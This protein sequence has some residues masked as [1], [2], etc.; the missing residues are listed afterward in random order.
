VL[1][2]LR[3]DLQAV[4]DRDPAARTTLEIIACYPGLHAIWG[5]RISHWLWSHDFKLIGRALSALTRLMT[6]VDIHPGATLGPGLFIDHATGVVIGESA[7]IG[8]DVTIY[9]GVTLGGTSRERGK[10]HPSVGDRVTLGAGAKVLGPV[11]I[12]SDSRVGANAVV[13][14]PVPANTI[15]VGVPGQII[16]RSRTAT[17]RLDLDGGVQP[18]LFG[19]SLRSLLG[20]VD[21]LEKSLPSH[22][23]ATST[24]SRPSEAG[25]WR[26]EDFSI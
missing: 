9:Q 17:A 19:V 11:T 2:T 8:A 10:R 6:G 7:D 14:K 21:E 23:T 16:S 5:H 24:H 15:V 25:V 1:A 26:G 4:R 20:R 3:Q 22:A 12:G 13:V 18:D